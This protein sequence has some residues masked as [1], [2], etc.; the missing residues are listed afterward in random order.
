ML[1][2]Q[3]NKLPITWNMDI[4]KTKVKVVVIC[5][6]A[7]TVMMISSKTAAKTNNWNIDIANA[8]PQH[9]HDC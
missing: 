9:Y 8:T 3:N 7:Q 2:L 5:N 6:A 4:D 1:T